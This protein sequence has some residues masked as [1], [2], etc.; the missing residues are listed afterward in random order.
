[1]LTRTRWLARNH[2][3]PVAIIAPSYASAVQ[4]ARSCAQALSA[5]E[6]K[7]RAER[8]LGELLAGIEWQ[9]GTRTASHDVTPLPTH[10]DH[11]I[12]RM[13]AHRWQIAAR[14]PEADFEAYVARE[15]AKGDAAELTSRAVYMLARRW[16]RERSERWRTAAAAATLAPWSRCLRPPADAAA[17]HL[18]I[19][20]VR[21]T[22]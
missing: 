19:E 7:L 13:S 21:R 18:S 17:V 9:Q 2:A 16:A 20:G 14:L 11:D 5:A 1:M 15:L 3:P 22:L 4:A 8:R 6:I 12:D 10:A